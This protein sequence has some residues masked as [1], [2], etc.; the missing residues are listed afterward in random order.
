MRRIRTHIVCLLLTLT[1]IFIL[2]QAEFVQN[3]G[4]WPEQVCFGSRVPGGEVYLENNAFTYVLVDPIVQEFLHPADISTPI[5]EAFK[6]HAYKVSFLGS[7]IPDVEGEKELGPY[8]NYYLGDDES[9]WASGAKS[10]GKAL[11]RNLYAQIDLRV[12]SK[13]AS[14]KYDFIVRAG[15]DFQNIRLGIEGVDWALKDGNLVIETSVGKVI[16]KAP[17]AYQ[18]IAGKI[19]DVACDYVIHKGVVQFDMG[20]YDL[21]YD[22]IIDPEVV[23][24]SYIGTTA[25]NFGFTATNDSEGNLIAGACVFAVGYPTT[26][27]AIQTDFNSGINSYCDAVI[28]KFNAVGDDLIYS[29]YL[30]GSGLEMPHSLIVDSDDNWIVMG[31]TGSADFPTTGGV[32]QEN[33]IGGPVFSFANFFIP[34]SHQS[35]CDFFVTKFNADG[36]GLFASTF[37][38]G[39]NTDGLNVA[40]KLFYNYG[41]SFRGEVIVDDEDNILVASNTASGDFPIVGGPQSGYAGG[42]SDGI[43]FKLDPML[44]D[45]L[46]S[47]YIGGTGDDSAYSLQIDGSGKIIVCGGT[48]SNGL[49]VTAG[50]ADDSFNGDVD[51]FIVKYNNDAS[52]VEACTYVG[53]SDYDQCYLVQLDGDDNIYV[54]GQSDGTMPI[55]GSVYSNP[56]SG[57]FISKYTS[58]LSDVIWST[59]IGTSSGAIDISPTAFLVSDCDQIYFSGWGG[60]TNTLNSNYATQSTTEGLPIT[61]DA[62]QDDTDGSDFYLCVLS[63]DAQ[64]LVYATFFGGNLSREHVDGGTSKFDK[65]G[66][67]YQAVCAGCGGYDDFPTTPGAWS[68]DNGSS[69]CNLGVFKFDLG[70]IQAVIEIDGPEQ[71]CEGTPA[72]FINNS[73]GGTDFQWDFGD[74][75]ISGEFEP[76]HNYEVNGFFEITLIVT[77]DTGCLSPDTATIT[78]E[79]LLGVNPII[80]E[81]DPVCEGESVTLFV[82][83]TENVYWLDNAT[84]SA[85]DIPNPVATPNQPTTYYAV[86]FNACESDTVGVFVDFVEVNTSISD[87]QTICIG[88][89]I[90]LLAEGGASYDWDPASSL[91]NSQVSN[92]VATPEETTT[93]T[94]SIVTLE[95]CEVEESVTI[96]VIL[97]APGG[98]VYPD[99]GLC[100]GFSVQL[101][102]NDGLAWVWSPSESLDNPSIQNPIASPSDTTTYTV[103]ITNACGVGVDQVTVNYIVP[104]AEAGSDGDV[105]LGQWYPVW[106]SGGEEYWWEPAAFVDNPTSANPQ[107]SPIETTTFTAYVTDEWGCTASSTVDVIVLPLPEVDAGPPRKIDWLDLAHIFG[108]AEGIEFW[109]EPDYNISCTDCLAPLVW[110]EQ[111]TWYTIFT[112][113]EHGCV[114]KD[115]TLIEVFL[116]VY[117]PNAFSPDNDGINDVFLPVS[118]H[119]RNFEMQ[120]YNRWGELIFETDDLDRPWDGSVRGS[121]HYVQIGVYLWV[122]WFDAREGR[123]QIQGHVTVVR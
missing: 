36:T 109:W 94:A 105:C 54:I 64:D 78:I 13:T 10:F 76:V 88:E 79:I 96:T 59:T 33:L 3:L 102:A 70:S 116:P 16:E 115:S 68:G 51:G 61:A 43:V 82:D 8:Y 46:W 85:T 62:Y 119:L 86:D 107:V 23:F 95:G 83:G 63:P 17:Y 52:S 27:G 19:I 67:V 104:Q 32:Y 2:A 110:P 84:L 106:A 65:D 111:D 28:T 50:V 74:G 9:K 7:Q 55:V 118:G 30:G 66:S 69:N 34:S 53:T 38:G 113:D 122:V 39:N 89:S 112:V 100:N 5:P 11:Y 123:K 101:M 22:V 14:L 93:Y 103:Q 58:D 90:E 72:V 91:D 18:I 45:L 21:A 6:M 24:A 42:V 47:T 31:T 114:N 71:V 48:K 20:V 99:I 92:P 35:G 1:P 40:D 15:G 37:V 29:T 98:E 41:D 87:N 77:D 108:Y 49:P 12:Y 97:D 57:Q 120:I 44:E 81:V 4:Q 75:T 26:L 56:L 121:D 117:V 25:S 80:D 73:T 60:W